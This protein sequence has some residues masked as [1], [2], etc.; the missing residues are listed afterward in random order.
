VNFKLKLN[1]FAAKMMMIHRYFDISA[2]ER[3]LK[4]KPIIAFEQVLTVMPVIIMNDISCPFPH[5][6]LRLGGLLT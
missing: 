1:P 2:A 6:F 3:D 5:A 4:Y